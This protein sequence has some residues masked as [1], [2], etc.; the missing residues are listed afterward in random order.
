MAH[1]MLPAK[2]IQIE[3]TDTEQ[4]LSYSDGMLLISLETFYND[5]RCAVLHL[6]EKLEAGELKNKR[7]VFENLEGLS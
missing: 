3:N 5:Y 7:I 6:I 1:C 2:T 4:H